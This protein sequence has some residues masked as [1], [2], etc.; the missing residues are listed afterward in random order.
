MDFRNYFTESFASI[1][2]KYHFLE[3][4]KYATARRHNE[5]FNLEQKVVE[6]LNMKATESVSL[7]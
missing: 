6:V 3:S 7:L 2:F 4:N 5:V 1:Y